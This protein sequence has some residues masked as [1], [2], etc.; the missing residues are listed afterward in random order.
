LRTRLS[1]RSLAR[2]GRCEPTASQRIL[3]TGTKDPSTGLPSAALTTA[4]ANGWSVSGSSQHKGCLNSSPSRRRNL[5]HCG[6]RGR[7]ESDCVDPNYSSGHLIPSLPN[8]ASRAALATV[9]VRWN[10][11]W[12][13][14]L[15][16]GLWRPEVGRSPIHHRV[17]HY[18]GFGRC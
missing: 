11:R 3:M 10:G 8:R 1:R 14:K 2:D 13:P 7:R 4:I 17:R 15:S 9:R 16:H 6:N 18:N 12:R 5:S